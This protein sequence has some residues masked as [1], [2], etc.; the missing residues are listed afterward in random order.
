MQNEP[1]LRQLS[2]RPYGN[3]EVKFERLLEL[4]LSVSDIFHTALSHSWTESFALNEY[5]SN[6]L[7]E[8]D[9]IV[10]KTTRY[11]NDYHLLTLGLKCKTSMEM[12]NTQA[13]Y[14]IEL[15]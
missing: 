13:Y 10:D 8:V 5:H 4:N 7:N 3:F 9:E 6:L 1:K 12:K 2:L 11:H 15:F 14:I